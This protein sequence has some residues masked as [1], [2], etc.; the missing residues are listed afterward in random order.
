[1]SA[2]ALRRVV[3][4]LALLTLLLALPLTALASRNSTETRLS[5]VID[6]IRV[7]L[8][9]VSTPRAGV[10]NNVSVTVLNAANH[11]PVFDGTTSV[12]V[13]APS[14]GHE[15]A[16]MSMPHDGVKTGGNTKSRGDTTAATSGAMPGHSMEGMSMPGHSMS[17]MSSDSMS[18]MSGHSMSGH[19]MSGMSMPD[20][21]TT[22]HS[23]SGHSMSHGTSATGRSAWVVLRPQTS[24]GVHDG[25]VKFEAPGRNRVDVAFS[26]KGKRRLASFETNVKQPRPR[27]VVFS[28]FAAA[29]LMVLLVALLLRRRGRQDDARRHAAASCKRAAMTG[30]PN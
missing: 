19:S 9:F 15:T 20:M 5:R 4:W 17:G 21:A 7:E 13:S 28:G 25:S 22:K 14:I 23:M 1:M 10:G 24:A 6:G 2:R 30:G 12:A 16:A 8:A 27:T 11:A 26:L 3:S 29:N 18:G